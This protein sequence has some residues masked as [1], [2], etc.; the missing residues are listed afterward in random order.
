MFESINLEERKK[1]TPEPLLQK[2]II[3]DFRLIENVCSEC[4]NGL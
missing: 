2:G 1:N 4:S 3:N